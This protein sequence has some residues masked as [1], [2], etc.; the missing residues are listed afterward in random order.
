MLYTVVPRYLIHSCTFKPPKQKGSWRFVFVFCLVQKYV[1]ALSMLAYACVSVLVCA[2]ACVC[3]L[4]VSVC[5]HAYACASMYMHARVLAHVISCHAW[6]FYEYNHACLSMHTNT[7][8][9]QQSTSIHPSLDPT[10]HSKPGLGGGFASIIGEDACVLSGICQLGAIDLQD[11]CG[12]L[13][14]NPQLVTW[15]Q[16]LAVL[17][18]KHSMVSRLVHWAQSTTWSFIG[19]IFI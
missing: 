18:P 5:I 15:L 8:P 3:V 6:I 19:A 17:L 13:T 14:A 9:P 10:L 16:C 2:R 12:S 7:H 1:C 11:G 4:C